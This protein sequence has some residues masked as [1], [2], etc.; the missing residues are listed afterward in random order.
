MQSKIVGSIFDIPLTAPAHAPSHAEKSLAV[1][2]T[3]LKTTERER[4]RNP[5]A[6]FLPLW[7]EF[8]QSTE[9]L[10][11]VTCA[12]PGA[13]Q[14]TLAK[15]YGYK[16]ANELFKASAVAA[17]CGPYD[18]EHDSYWNSEDGKERAAERLARTISILTT[19][20]P[21]L[22]VDSPGPSV[23]VI[24]SLQLFSNIDAQHAAFKELCLHKLSVAERTEARESG[25]N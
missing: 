8:L 4:A 22:L 14:N 15:I 25:A 17:Y 10:M 19:D 20:C 13:S 5:L 24:R 21:W 3:A 12:K 6:K 2:A 7:E 16:H 11:D 23:H 18:D 9:L 1:P